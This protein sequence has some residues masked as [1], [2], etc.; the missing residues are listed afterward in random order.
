MVPVAYTT[1]SA[2]GSIVGELDVKSLRRDRRAVPWRRQGKP[3][4]VAAPACRRRASREAD[5]AAGARARWSRRSPC[6]RACSAACARSD[7]ASRTPE[8]RA[9]DRQHRRR[10]DRRQRHRD[11]D[12]HERE[13]ACAASLRH[14]SVRVGVDGCADVPEQ[15]VQRDGHRDRARCEPSGIA[16]CVH[17]GRARVRVGGVARLWCTPI[18]A[19]PLASRHGSGVGGVVGGQRAV[20]VPP[21]VRHQRLQLRTAPASTPRSRCARS[22][23]RA[24]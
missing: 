12:L 6:P 3:A 10:H 8:L 20:T 16:S 9:H 2:S 1:S 22:W 5:A 17:D 13:A 21:C 18:G 24:R 11:Q 19:T 7:P 14:P 23:R 15:S 4:L